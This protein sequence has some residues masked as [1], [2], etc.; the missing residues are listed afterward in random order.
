MKEYIKIY[1][2][3]KYFLPYLSRLGLRQF[4]GKRL[5]RFSGPKNKIT[6]PT[7]SK[8]AANKHLVNLKLLYK[9]HVARPDI[10]EQQD[11]MRRLFSPLTKEGLIT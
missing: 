8:F 10:F 1:Y 2:H 5:D 4:F 11:Q 7:A 9:F 3:L 6:R